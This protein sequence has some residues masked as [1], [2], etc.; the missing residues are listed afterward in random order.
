MTQLVV[1]IVYMAC[2]LAIG[3]LSNR[4]FKGTAKDYYTASHSIGPVILLL[5]LFGTAM[6]AF[7]LVGSTS[8]AYRRG[9]GVYG[10]MAS[11]SGLIHAGV[12]YFVGIRLWAFGKRYGYV[13]QIQF[14]RDRFESGFLGVL[15]F[16]ILV[17][18]LI[19]YILTGVIGSGTIVNKITAGAFPEAFKT[20]DGGV[21]PWITALVVSGITL[22]YIFYGGLRSAAWAETFQ[23]LVFMTMGVAAFF[24]IASKLGGAVAASKLVVEKNPALLVRAGKIHP[25]EFLSYGFV[26]LSIGM[27]PHM[28]QHWLTAKSAKSFRL[29]V[30]GFPICIMIVW[31]PCIL[32]GIWA[33]VAVIPGTDKLIVPPNAPPNA[34]LGIMIKKLATPALGGFLGAGV[35]AAIMSTLDT[36]FLSL[37]TMFT[38]DVIVHFFGKE[39][40]SDRQQIWMAR[41]FVVF[42]V[43]IVFILSLLP[44][45][46]IFSLGVWCFSGFTSLFPLVFAAIYWKRVTKFGALASVAVAAVVWFILFAR[47]GFGTSKEESLVFGM[48]PVATIII[49]SALT[50]VVVSL[51]TPPPSEKTLLKFFP[52]SLKP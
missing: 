29:T 36:Q 42:I 10:L 16:P 21:P 1:I 30:T 46:R 48:M 27:F 45:P 49:C 9:I 2:L 28:F 13:T 41:S 37:S 19:P 22:M 3:L 51:L 20:T 34:E 38:N 14:F 50:L 4:L 43:T 32:I 6:T 52:D 18:L 24:V 26:P 8:E 11:W 47:A 23:T 5:S 33:T 39:R 12:F 35:L 44:M 25:L 17:G 7:A 15:L 31:L 40:F